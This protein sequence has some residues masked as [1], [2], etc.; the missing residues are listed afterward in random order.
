MIL[1]ISTTAQVDHG[2]NHNEEI[3]GD[4]NYWKLFIKNSQ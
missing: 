3:T 4:T 2:K 1:K